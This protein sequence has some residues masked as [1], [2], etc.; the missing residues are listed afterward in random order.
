MTDT[1][2]D[3]ALT[4]P[5][6]KRSL[7][8]RIMAVMAGLS[9]IML[10]L[11]LVVGWTLR[12]T[13]VAD[14]RAGVSTDD[15]T[16]E[17]GPEQQT[18]PMPDVRGL[19]EADARQ[20]ISDAGYDPGAVAI[21]Q[22]PFVGRAGTVVAQDPAARSSEVGTI[23]LSIPVEATMPDLV[24]KPLDEAS[25]A[26]SALGSRPSIKR[27]YVAGAATGSVIS[28]DPAAGGVLIEEPVV[29]VAS[30]AGTLPL[31]TVKSS[32]SCGSKSSGTVNGTKTTTGIS[33]SARKTQSSTSW[34][35]A[36]AA[37]RLQATVGLDDASDPLAATRIRIVADGRT[38]FDEVVK[39]G[40]SVKVDVDVSNVLRLEVTVTRTDQSTSDSAEV[41]LA[42]AVVAGGAE[43]LS[44]IEA[45]S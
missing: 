35:I 42:N 38:V 37:A 11:G 34:I 13:L 10:I 17:A 43:S 2:G 8:F 20:V 30:A 23:T 28:T 33:C 26:L 5:A 41:V 25:R 36:R 24:G 3:E 31:A 14:E 27:T 22:I 12:G 6:K 45:F 16:S 44:K 9:S 18:E 7:W 1:V 32:G 40:Q 21:N 4:I 39:Y 19:S 15:S 29:T